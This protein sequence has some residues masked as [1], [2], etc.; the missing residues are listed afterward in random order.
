VDQRTGE[1]LAGDGKHPLDLGGMVWCFVSGVEKEGMNRREAQISD[2][3]A[4]A[5]VLLNFVQERDDR[6]ASMS[7]RFS[8]DGDLCRRC[9]TNLS[10]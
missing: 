10:N 6:G 5:V 7:S 2:A 4:N 8:C 3:N 1:A 9:C